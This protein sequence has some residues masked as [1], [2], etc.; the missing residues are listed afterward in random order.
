MKDSRPPYYKY[1]NQ[2]LE[3]LDGD[4]SLIFGDKF[5]YPRQFEIHLPSDHKR[6]CSL[7]C[8]HCAGIRF[9]KDLGRWEIE[10]LELLDNLKGA[11]PYHIYGG[12][13]TE[14]LLNPYYLTFLAYTKKYN[15]HFGIHTNGVLLNWLEE[16]QGWL[17]E[18]NKLATDET[19]YLSISI[20]AG[21]AWSWAKTKG[22]RKEKLFF[23]ILRGLNK[24]CRIRN[25]NG[26]THAIRLCYLISPESGTP[27]NF[28]AI[29]SIAKEIGVDSLRFSIPFANYNQSFD[30]VRDY[31]RTVEVIGDIKYR[32]LLEEFLSTNQDERPYIFYSGPEFTWVDNFTFN[33]CIYGF[34]QVTVGADGYIYKCSTTA[35][36]TAKHCRLGKITSNLDSFKEM[37]V[38]NYNPKWDCRTMCF[39]KGLRCNRMGIECNQAYDRLN[40]ES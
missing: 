38:K 6:A 19:D 39:D 33:K 1:W 23:E 31:K 36:P 21:L 15:N 34:Y 26:K 12:A 18:L 10:A 2:L 37:I 29:V 14:P 30:K 35:T 8:P 20:D 24:A 28:S 5:V 11:I 9:K 7:A 32:N 17:T 22:T 27:E 13:Y 3:H 4:T 16:E 40:R 25:R